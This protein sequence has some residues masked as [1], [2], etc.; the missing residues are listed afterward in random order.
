MGVCLV[1]VRRGVMRR[2]TK[3]AS[4][5][6][7][8]HRWPT[9]TMRRRRHGSSGGVWTCVRC[10]RGQLQDIEPWG[11]NYRCCLAA[12][13]TTAGASASDLS[14][15]RAKVELPIAASLAAASPGRPVERCSGFPPAPLATAAE[16]G[17]GVD[18][19][20]RSTAGRV[21]RLPPPRRLSE[22]AWNRPY[23]RWSAS[24][25]ARSEGDGR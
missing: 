23:W 9:V 8:R 18:D 12:F 20:H 14:K 17:G 21:A 16:V 22:R 19:R 5:R 6:R 10:P 15:T 4:A 1:G 2:Q 25:V 13:R 7:T 24:G 3:A 11:K